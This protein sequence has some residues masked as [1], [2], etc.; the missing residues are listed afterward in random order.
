MKRDNTIDLLRGIAILVV[1]LGHSILY[2]PIEMEAMYPWCHWLVTSIISFNMPM[3]FILSGYLF[4]KSQKGVKES[5]EGKV[6]RLLIPYLFTMAILIGMKLVLPT[7]MSY[8]KS[9]GGGFSSL[10]INALCY[11]GDCWFVYVMFIICV[12]LIPFKKLLN[13]TWIPM[14]FIAALTG[15]YFLKV[16]PNFMKLGDVSYFMEFFLAGYI[17]KNMW[18]NM[19]T[20]CA[21]YWYVTIPLFLLANLLF[22]MPLTKIPFVFRF[23]LPFTGFF[24][25]QSMAELLAK[26]ETALSKSIA[27]CGKYSLQ[28]Y[29]FTFC[30]PIIRWGIVSVLHVTNPFVILLSVFV[31]QLITITIIVEISRR[32]QFL[33]IPCGY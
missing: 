29:L 13:R 20:F 16:M 6:K 26:K 17:M 11:G 25:S 4:A 14:I 8:N 27:Y 31:L 2:H 9:V 24:A 1:Y 21:K 22:V 33:K 10:V 28:F 30:Y 15:L 23:I 32:I 3:F 19:K 7:S 12:I 18:P 5:Y